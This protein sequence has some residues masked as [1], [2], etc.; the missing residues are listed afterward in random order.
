MFRK[1]EFSVSYLLDSGVKNQPRFQPQMTSSRNSSVVPRYSELLED[2][3]ALIEESSTKNKTLVKFVTEL[4]DRG[5]DPNFICDTS[6]LGNAS[7]QK[8][9]NANVRGVK[10]MA[11]SRGF[12]GEAVIFHPKSDL[13]KPVDVEGNTLL[14]EFVPLFGEPN[15]KLCYKLLNLKPKLTG[16]LNNKG[17]TPLNKICALTKYS[18]DTKIFSEALTTASSMLQH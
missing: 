8:P 18:L 17:Q 10:Y 13:E 2:D 6:D 16:A 1:N 12:I 14:H 15:F 4:I 5:A 9:S 7:V 11:I 3:V